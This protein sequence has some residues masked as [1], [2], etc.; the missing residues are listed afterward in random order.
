MTLRSGREGRAHRARPSSSRRRSNAN[1]PYW[2]MIVW[3]AFPQTTSAPD[4]T[5]VEIVHDVFLPM[6]AS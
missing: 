4:S 6:V 3:P 2:L 1:L 5:I